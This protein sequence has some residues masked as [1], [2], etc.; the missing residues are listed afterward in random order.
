MLRIDRFF[1]L[2][3]SRDK[4]MQVPLPIGYDVVPYVVHGILLQIPLPGYVIPCGEVSGGDDKLEEVG[5]RG[6]VAPASLPD[7]FCQQA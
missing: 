1:G 5:I 2:L 3:G 4:V 6:V 7:I